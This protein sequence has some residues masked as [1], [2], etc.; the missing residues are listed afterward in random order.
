[1]HHVCNWLLMTYTGVL[2]GLSRDVHGSAVCLL[3]PLH[4]SFCRQG[5]SELDSFLY[6]Q[7]FYRGVD[8]NANGVKWVMVKSVRSVVGVIMLSQYESTVS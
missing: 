3:N 1:M 2:Q 6:T 5:V 7:I 4:T 8:R